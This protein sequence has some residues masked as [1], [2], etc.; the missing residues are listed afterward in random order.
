MRKFEFVMKVCGY[1]TIEVKSD[2]YDSAKEKAIE[3][4][5]EMDFG[6]LENIDYDFNN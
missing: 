5:N 3:E 1:V 6:P 2:N 4:C